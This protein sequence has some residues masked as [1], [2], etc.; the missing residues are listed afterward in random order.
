MGRW[1]AAGAWALLLA[2]YLATAFNVVVPHDTSPPR[3]H[4][5][6]VFLTNVFDLPY[7][8]TAEDRDAFVT[9]TLYIVYYTFWFEA[10]D[11]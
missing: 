5:F 4:A 9:T 1:T 11:A 3:P 8:I 7:L 2:C 6:L 10:S